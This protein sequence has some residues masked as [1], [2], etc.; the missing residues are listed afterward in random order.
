MT[1][2]GQLWP[3][4]LLSFN[5]ELKAAFN[6]DELGGGQSSTEIETGEYRKREIQTSGFARL[7]RR[8]VITTLNLINHEPETT[9][10]QPV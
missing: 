1:R 10:P 5:G 8:P 2:I 9:I 6:S 3:H 7:W 4:R